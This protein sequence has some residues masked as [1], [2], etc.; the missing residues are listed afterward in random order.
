MAPD[1]WSAMRSSGCVR[2]GRAIP[3]AAAGAWITPNPLRLLSAS[4]SAGSSGRRRSAPP[5][6]RTAARRAGPLPRPAREWRQPLRPQRRL[7]LQVGSERALEVQAVSGRFRDRPCSQ[8]TERAFRVAVP[9]ELSADRCSSGK[10]SGV[11]TA[12]PVA[13]PNVGGVQTGVTECPG[14]GGVV[15]ANVHSGQEDRSHVLTVVSEP[16]PGAAAHA[17]EADDPCGDV[18]RIV[19]VAPIKSSGMLRA[20]QKRIGII[21][22]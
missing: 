18:V 8:Y 4:K 17:L 3:P 21:Y 2:A 13:E 22:Q 10:V 20:R 9:Y 12:G 6:W 5:C 19:G 16:V 15:S 7:R 11:S 1:P 14:I